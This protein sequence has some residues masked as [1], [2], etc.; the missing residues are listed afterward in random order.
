MFMRDSAIIYQ[1]LLVILLIL[2]FIQMGGNTGHAQDKRPADV[3]QLTAQLAQE[4]EKLRWY[5]G[6]PINE[7][8]PPVVTDVSPHE[9]YFQAK[10]LVRKSSKLSFELTFEQHS[11][12]EAPVGRI[13]PRD[14]YELVRVASLQIRQIAEELNLKDLLV[15]LPPF[16]PTK[17]PTDVFKLVV[18]TSRQLNLLIYRNISPSDVYQTVT[19]AISY[20]DA[21]LNT[22][23]NPPVPPQ[24]IPVTPG[25]RPEDV[26]V[27]LHETYRRVENIGKKMGLDMMTLERWTNSKDIQPSDVLD[28]ASTIVAGLTHIHENSNGADTPQPIRWQHGMFP[29]DVFNRVLVLESQLDKIEQRI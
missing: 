10:L 21:I 1:S 23:P 22:L 28:L 25:K 14:V 8:E 18:Q 3:Y 13:K 24:A 2:P 27:K 19:T 5:M 15:P 9:V 11:I 20:T 7:Q 17:T 12:P 29:S 6:R 26:F 4:V 16:D